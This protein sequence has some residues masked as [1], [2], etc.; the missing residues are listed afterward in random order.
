MAVAS[1]PP[2]TSAPAARTRRDT[3]ALVV[4]VVSGLLLLAVPT[5]AAV[6]VLTGAVGTGGYLVAT[7][8]QFAAQ[9]LSIAQVAAVLWWVRCGREEDRLRVL[10][11]VALGVVV[12]ADLL[13]VTL[14]VVRSLS[15]S[16]LV[17]GSG[18]GVVGALGVLLTV[19]DALAALVLVGLAVLALLR[20]GRAPR[21]VRAAP[22][23]RTL[24]LLLV[25][26]AAL[27]GLA[28]PAVDG[29]MRLSGLGASF[30]SATFVVLSLLRTVLHIAV[31]LVAALAIARSEARQHLLAWAVPVLL[32]CGVLAVSVLNR[33]VSGMYLAAPEDPAAIER[34]R[35][36]IGMV[37]ELLAGGAATAA[38]VA[39]AVL[40]LRSRTPGPAAP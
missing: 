11:L 39:L 12:A 14:D 25:P 40:A 2:P 38:A 4:L 28:L 16:L 17:P 15:F 3:G 27:L 24:A 19:V 23:L 9:V 33:V 29:V 35:D 37:L 32:W 1:S 26:L 36:I 21:T 7:T 30:A 10:P 22:A 6:Q 20:R 31:L 13:A 5:A 8:V 18:M 34:T